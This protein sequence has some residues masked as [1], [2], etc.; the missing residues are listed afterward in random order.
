M[1][2]AYILHILILSGIFMILIMALNVTLGFTGLI[3]LGHVA[4]FGLGAYASALMSL[5]GVPF[6]LAAVLGSLISAMC[7]LVLIRLLAH[8]QGD[9]L[10]LATLGFAF[11]FYAVALNWTSLTHGP[12]GLAGIPRPA[13]FG[14]VFRTPGSMALLVLVT[15]LV[16]LGF[17]TRLFRSRRGKL[18]EAVRD[19]EIGL[20]AL[21]K[22][23]SRLKYESVFISAFLAGLAGAFYASYVGFLDPSQFYITPLAVALT[24]VI[25]GGLG[26][27][28]GSILG[29]LIMTVLPEALRFVPLPLS[30]LGPMREFLYGF[31][32]LVVLR[33]RP[34][35]L[36]GRVDIP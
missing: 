17:L 25:V 12:I 7:G 29:A 4:L 26:S 14:F 11:V 31:I 3:N 16:V 21:G 19:D 34:R 20:A 33:I 32:L 2:S 15:A 10:A 30:L 35:G 8:V 18:F 1:L 24:M 27:V 13:I 22:D 5:H 36:L 6:F 23:V 28:W 9:Y